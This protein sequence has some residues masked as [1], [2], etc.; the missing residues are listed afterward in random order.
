MRLELTIPTT[1]TRAQD[2]TRSVA[3]AP[4]GAVSSPDVLLSWSPLRILPADLH[5][6][7]MSELRANVSPAG[8]LQVLTDTICLT[9]TGWSVRII[10]AVVRSIGGGPATEW[11]TGAF[12][13]FFEHAGSAMVLATDEQR[14]RDVLPVA[15]AILLD[16]RP[17]W[18]GDVASLADIWDVKP[19]PRARSRPVVPSVP[20]AIAP[21]VS[22]EAD[23]A[24]AHFARANALAR[25][26]DDRG[27]IVEWIA[28]ADA[29]PTDV[30]GLYNAGLAHYRLGDLAS[31]LSAWDR[32][33][34]RRP[35]NYWLLRK[36]LQALVG[37]GRCDEA[38]TVRAM[39]V[40]VWTTSADP[41]VR[42]QDELVFDQFPVPGAA[43]LSVFAFQ[44]LRPHDSKS[45]TVYTFRVT[46]G[47]RRMDALEVAVE[48][49]DYAKERAMPFVVSL[50][51]ATRY[52]VLL[53]LAR[54]PRY[55]ELKALVLK[56]VT[57]TLGT[58]ARST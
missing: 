4:A 19:P 15:R 11:R 13:A 26:G 34:E 6:W 27:A 36:R 3:L 41:S 37:L 46:D 40:E 42:M 22:L 52:H 51:D 45:C 50:H 58:R 44:T 54:L 8:D 23:L 55:P 14:Y 1:W 33:L 21:G 53:T 9:T 18:S 49:S 31:A 10:D 17:H 16:A 35:G 38:D 30:D 2:G 7:V 32:G 29:D 47:E 24:G 25:A 12:Y 39:L 43:G 20:G 5:A 48:T 28:A 57:E 56:L